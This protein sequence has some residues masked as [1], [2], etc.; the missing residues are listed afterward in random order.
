MFNEKLVILNII[1]CQQRNCVQKS[2]KTN[3]KT[4]LLRK[5]NVYSK[6]SQNKNHNLNFYSRKNQLLLNVSN[7]TFFHSFF[8]HAQTDKT[9]ERNKERKKEK[10]KKDRKI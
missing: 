5:L 6:H 8:S 10:I 4:H 3:A 1:N 2:N 7:S 9:F